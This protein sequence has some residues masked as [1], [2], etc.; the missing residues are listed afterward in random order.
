MKV[1]VATTGEYSDYQIEAIFSTRKK[2]EEYAN[3][4]SVNGLR[5]EV[6]LMDV[7]RPVKQVFVQMAKDGTV[8]RIIGPDMKDAIDGRGDNRI[9]FTS[10]YH[11]KLDG[12]EKTLGWWVETD[13]KKRAVKVVNEKRIQ[14]LAMGLWG[15]DKAVMEYTAEDTDW[16]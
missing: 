14:I 16:K 1:Y 8:I 5:I 15:N 13:S 12:K 2:A 3:F 10:F 9:G 6:W 4:H 11:L 7:A